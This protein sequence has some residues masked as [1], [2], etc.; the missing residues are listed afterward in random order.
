MSQFLQGVSFIHNYLIEIN[1]N[2]YYLHGDRNN[3]TRTTLDWV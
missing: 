1:M 2:I 3:N